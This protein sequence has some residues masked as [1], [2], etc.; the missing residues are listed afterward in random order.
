MKSRIFSVIW[1]AA[2]VTACGGGGG[3]QMAGI[4]G[5]GSPFTPPV[6]TAV[7]SRG[8][9]SGF[10]SVIVNGVRFDV[11]GAT[12]TIDGSP[13][14]E[15]DLE[16]GQVV[17]I[18]G[19]LDDSGSTGTADSLSFDDS[20]EGPISAIDTVAGTIVVLGQTVFVDASTSFDGALSLATLSVGDVIEVTGF[21]RA[22]GSTSATRIEAKPPG[23]TFEVTGIANNVSAT[24][25]EINDLVV[26]YSAAMLNDFPGGAPVN[27]QLVE[28]KG[29]SLGGAG[30]L[31]ATSVEFKGGDLTGDD[32]DRIEVEGFITRFSSPTDFDVEDVPVT[33]N[34]QTV[35][36]FGTSA[37]LALNRKVEVE[38]QIDATGLVTAEK[39]ELKQAGF[40]RIESTVESVQSDQLTVLGIAVTVNV[41]TRIEDKS[42]AEVEPFSLAD[43]NVGDYVELRGFEDGSGVVATQVERE[44]FDGEVALRGFVESVSNPDLSILGV[45]I[46]TNGATQFE[47]LNDQPITSA[48]FFGQAQGRLVEA[49]GTLSNGM[50]I[51]EEVD[52]EN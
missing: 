6:V 11:S 45:T 9:I 29:L 10:G 49:K 50:I 4:D 7:V 18:R 52:L 28:A 8:T 36:E 25:F 24:T 1:V 41:S 20:V 27:G 48:T 12:I 46:Q 32:G 23:G 39:I 35:F 38:G 34:A 3:S 31:L 22:D 17:T 26:D 14:I 16:V 43:I 2:V 5:G 37:D 21:V 15:A 40:I 19:T 42:S 13:G 33:T 44:D 47:D 30:E 51:A